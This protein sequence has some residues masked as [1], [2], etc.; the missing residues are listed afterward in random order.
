MLF[1]SLS[2][3]QAALAPAD[4]NFYFYAL[5]TKAE[6]RQ[7]HFSKNLEE[8]EAFLASLKES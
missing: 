1:R 2:S 8:H 4:T 3:I 6:E 7:H 5:D